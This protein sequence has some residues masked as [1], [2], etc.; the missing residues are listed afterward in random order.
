MGLLEVAYSLVQEEQYPILQK[1]NTKPTKNVK[2]FVMDKIGITSKE[3]ELV[4]KALKI[5]KTPVKALDSKLT[6]DSAD[7]R[8]TIKAA[9][10]FMKYTE[11]GKLVAKDKH[12]SVVRFREG[13]LATLEMVVYD[14]V[15]RSNEHFSSKYKDSTSLLKAIDEIETIG[16]RYSVDYGLFQLNIRVDTECFGSL[17][18]CAGR[19]HSSASILLQPDSRYDIDEILS[20]NYNTL[21]EYSNTLS[22]IFS[23]RVGI[24]VNQTLI[25]PKACPA[26]RTESVRKYLYLEEIQRVVNEFVK[27]VIPAGEDYFHYY[28]Q[29]VEHVLCMAAE[30][31][32]LDVVYSKLMECEKSDWSTVS[33]LCNVE[34]TDGF[35]Y[36]WIDRGSES[37]YQFK[38]HIKVNLMGFAFENDYSTEYMQFNS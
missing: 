36:R 3:V 32:S 4:S 16:V 14:R 30:T 23:D 35:G 5:S 31:L 7:Y 26:E 34:L 22:A 2:Q 17:E 21:Q 11:G 15:T 38:G 12:G 28:A 20:V 37:G 19:Y 8:R 10:T 27:R 24:R 6:M 25:E 33:E 9:V 1:V 13:N 29:M 18:V